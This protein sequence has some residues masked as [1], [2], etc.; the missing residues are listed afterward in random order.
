MGSTVN[1]YLLRG[2]LE[3]IME[4]IVDIQSTH[5]DVVYGSNIKNKPEFG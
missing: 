1:N 4:G 2:I 3:G 5:G